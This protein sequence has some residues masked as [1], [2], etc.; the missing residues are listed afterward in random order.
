MAHF[1]S[2]ICT[3]QH[4]FDV[5][6]RGYVNFLSRVSK[7]KYD[8]RLFESRRTVYKSGFFEPLYAIICD[9]IV[10]QLHTGEQIKIL[11][12]GCGEGSL[13]TSVKE[14]I[15]QNMS[16]SLLA[17]GIDISR[18]GVDSAAKAYSNAIWCVA[19]IANF[20]FADQQFHY[21]LNILSP[22]NYQEFQRMIIGGGMVIKV[23]P[24]QDYLKELRN[25]FYE[26]SR[27]QVYAND[28]TLEHFKENFGMTDIER[29][30]YQADV[31]DALIEPLLRMTPLS[32]GTTEERWQKVRQ[33][34]LRQVTIDLTILFGRNIC[35]L[36]L[37]S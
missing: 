5:S 9:K 22:A 29:V 24:G 4:C 18:E 20:P 21:I 8:Q 36:E 14:K 31:D 26:G 35:S 17:V 27:K 6:K 32:W 7:S 16:T 11:D 23:I 28:L 19:D 1:Q 12:A 3:N 33:M 15:T 13:L 2:L 10:K 25:I 34:K 37:S 30:R